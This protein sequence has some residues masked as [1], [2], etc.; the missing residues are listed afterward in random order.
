MLMTLSIADAT[1]EAGDNSKNVITKQNMSETSRKCEY[2]ELK[3]EPIS[4]NALSHEEPIIEIADTL[5]DLR[6]FEANC[7]GIQRC[8]GNVNPTSSKDSRQEDH[9]TDNQPKEDDANWS[10]TDETKTASNFDSSRK[11]LIQELPK[12]TER[13]QSTTQA[14]Q[15]I[16]GQLDSE[17]RKEISSD[18]SNDKLHELMI[19]AVKEGNYKQMVVPIDIW[20]FGGQKDYHMTHQLFL[21]SRGIFIL[22]F[23][24]CVDIHK[25]IPE[26]GFLPGHFGK[27][28]V[29]G[30]S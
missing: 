20:D 5:E 17:W 3:A 2:Q 23:N 24:G 29:A 12:K 26:L 21:T 8:D 7:T 19:K 14:I 16:S 9:S 22:M 1:T 18:L 11:L 10:S 6:S 27:P 28:T 13:N 4:S 15:I 30:K 25:H